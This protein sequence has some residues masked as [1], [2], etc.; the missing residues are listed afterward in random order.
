MKAGGLLAARKGCLRKVG[1]E[2][3]VG[4]QGLQAFGCQ[5]PYR[6]TIYHDESLG[7]VSAVTRIIEEQR[8]VGLVHQTL[9]WERKFMLNMC[10]GS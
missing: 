1:F 4:H 9:R 10:G 6:P 2:E 8:Q 3:P 5:G 7:S